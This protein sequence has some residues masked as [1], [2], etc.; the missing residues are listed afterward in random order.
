MQCDNVS[1]KGQREMRR[2]DNEIN[3]LQ[4]FFFLTVIS[5]VEVSLGLTLWVFFL[6]FFSTDC[7]KL[8][9][10]HAVL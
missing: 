2:A 8:T 9:H 1:F 3:T 10:M 7:T 6:W 4:P 5:V